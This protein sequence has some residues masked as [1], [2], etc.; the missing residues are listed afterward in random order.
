M[1][2]PDKNFFQ[3]KHLKDNDTNLFIVTSHSMYSLDLQ[4][5]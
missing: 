1:F 2:F 5:S 4:N 3:N